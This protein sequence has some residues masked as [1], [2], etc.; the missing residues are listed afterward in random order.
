MAEVRIEGG[1]ELD[2]AILKGAATEATLQ[3]LVKVMQTMTAGTKAAAAVQKI[4]KGKATSDKDLADLRKEV[5]E[6]T[7]QFEKLQNRSKVAASAIYDFGK[8][9]LISGQ[10]FGDFTQSITSFMATAGPGFFILGAGIQALVN[11]TDRQ[12]EVFRQLSTVGADFGDG[13]F[14][15]RMASIEA[16]LTLGTFATEVSANTDLFSRLGGNV[17]IG[18]RTFTRL[19]RSSERV[20]RGLHFCCVARGFDVLQTF[21]LTVTHAHVVNRQDFDRIFFGELVFIHAHDDVF[22][23]VDARLLFSSSGFDF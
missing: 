15:S 13:I 11:E 23:R 14:G 19:S 2:G 10:K 18:T 21:D 20:Q 5:N 9:A 7:N 6:T 3:Q 1:G 12:V 17:N 4:A 8:T 16:G 22:A